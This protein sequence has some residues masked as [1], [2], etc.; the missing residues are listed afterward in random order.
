MKKCLFLIAC[1]ATTVL[2]QGRGGPPNREAPVTPVPFER[3]LRANQEPQNWLTYSGN[4][5]PAPQ[6]PH[7]DHSG[8]CQEPRLKWVFQSRSLEKHEV[9]PLVVDGVMYTIQSTNDVIALD[10]A[11]GKT[12]WTYSHK[13]DAGRAQSAAAT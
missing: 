13:P 12:I 5:Q 8:Q 1:A 2:G 10:A 6:R 4:S 3:I 7:A 9:T 11:T